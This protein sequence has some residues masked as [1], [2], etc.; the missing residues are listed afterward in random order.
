MKNPR[1][2]DSLAERL[3]F[4]CYVFVPVRSSPPNKLYWLALGI[5]AGVGQLFKLAAIR[6]V[7]NG[8]TQS[9]E[10]Q[11]RVVKFGFCFLIFAV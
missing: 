8:I 5:S 10:R 11:L 9:I 3:T 6:G 4:R 1:C 7:S 2:C